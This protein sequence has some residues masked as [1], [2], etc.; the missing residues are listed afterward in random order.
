VTEWLLI[1]MLV[2]IAIAYVCAVSVRHRLSLVQ[3]R[4]AVV[5]MATIFSIS[6]IVVAI[7]GDESLRSR[8]YP[9]FVLYALATLCF[10]F[11]YEVT[12]PASS[13][14]WSDE[15]RYDLLFGAAGWIL[16]GAGVLAFGV[17]VERYGLEFLWMAKSDVYLLSEELGPEKFAKD[18]V[19]TG[20]IILAYD[21]CRRRRFSVAFVTVYL[22]T[23]AV[24]VALSR[25]S[26]LLT[27][28]AATA[29]YYHHAVRP[30]R[31]RWLVAAGIAGLVVGGAWNQVY[32]LLLGYPGYSF[33]ISDQEWWTQNNPFYQLRSS[34]EIW[35]N[36]WGS[37]PELGR[38]YINAAKGVLL[39][40]FLGGQANSLGAWYMERFVADQAGTGVGVAFSGLVESY[41]NFGLVGPLMVFTLLG[42][43]ARKAD[44]MSPTRLLFLRGLAF[45]S[46][47][48]IFMGEFSSFLKFQIVFFCVIPYGAYWAF[49]SVRELMRGARLA[50]P[51]LR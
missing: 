12:R 37:Q 3:F 19:M 22:G 26:M 8:D 9:R 28:L 21:A 35:A 30:L 44:T 6:P 25:R 46:L 49:S 2:S 10:I 15:T 41:I 48:E 32:G 40:R 17:L 39:P 27:T 14:D 11:A 23:L 33:T 1:A 16:I 18:L 5:G 51:P 38:T 7:L 20:T 4:F 29:F 13:R 24:G 34:D 31:T 36:V 43:L 42:F 45:G 50:P 47:P